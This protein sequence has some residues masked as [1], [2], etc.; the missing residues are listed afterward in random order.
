MCNCSSSKLV[1]LKSISGSDI[2]VNPTHII[3]VEQSP[4]KDPYFLLYLSGQNCCVA[5]EPT[6]NLLGG[7]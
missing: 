5:A 3:K 4:R 1:K 6:L 2:W 7:L